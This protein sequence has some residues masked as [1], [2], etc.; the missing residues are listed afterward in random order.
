MKKARSRAFFVLS[1]LGCGTEGLAV[2]ALGLSGVGLMRADSDHVQRAV[3]LALAVISTLSY[4]AGN[5]LI[6]R[7]ATA[8][9]TAVLVH[10]ESSVC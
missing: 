1:A 5:A 2:C 4:G 8:A 3:I 9:L 10:L 7:A 6:A